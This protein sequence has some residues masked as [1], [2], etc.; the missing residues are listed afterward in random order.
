[1]L[2]LFEFQKN[3]RKAKAQANSPI[4]VI[5]DNYSSFNV[6]SDASATFNVSTDLDLPRRRCR[7]LR[8][9]GLERAGAD[10]LVPPPLLLTLRLHA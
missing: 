6:Y 4:P 2:I 5:L 7:R 10:P 8:L 1:M 3:F 9:M